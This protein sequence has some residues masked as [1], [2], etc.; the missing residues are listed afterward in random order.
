MR[1]YQ[2]TLALGLALL[3]ACGGPIPDPEPEPGAA[4]G[5]FDCEI[6]IEEQD[7]DF[8]RFRR[9]ICAFSSRKAEAR[10]EEEHCEGKGFADC[11]A[12]CG[13]EDWLLGPC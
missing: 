4:L 12:Y 9:G 2:A 13:A 7:G 3:M 6:R 5:F 11:Y 8:Q 1:I 10:L